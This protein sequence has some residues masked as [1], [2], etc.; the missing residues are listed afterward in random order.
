MSEVNEKLEQFR[1]YLEE[2]GLRY[3]TQ[4]RVIVEAFYGSG[5]HLSLNEVLDL[6]RERQPSIGF[7]TVYR[8]MKLLATKA[9]SPNRGKPRA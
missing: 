9:S 3:T 1:A 4:R 6:S 7:A 5:K 8:T 2:K